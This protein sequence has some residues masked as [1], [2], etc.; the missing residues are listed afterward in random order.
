VQL[1]TMMYL[2][3]YIDR[4]N[5]SYAKLTMIGD[6]RYDRGRVRVRLVAV[7]NRL[8]DLRGSEQSR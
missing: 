6:I 4:A 2:I 3:G 7:L 8:F 5:L 1:L